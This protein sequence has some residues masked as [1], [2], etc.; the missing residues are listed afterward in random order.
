MLAHCHDIVK[1]R[2]KLS[3]EDIILVVQLDTAMMK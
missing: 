2:E 1:H 3:A